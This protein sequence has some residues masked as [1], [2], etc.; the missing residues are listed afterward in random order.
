MN[1]MEL[2]Q[3]Y[4]LIVSLG[5]SCAPAINMRNYGLRKFSMPLDWMISFSLSDVNRL[6]LNKFEQFMILDN[7]HKL[8]ETHYFL[9]DGAPATPLAENS[10]LKSYFIRD[11]LYNII[12]AHDFPIVEGEHWSTSYPAFRAKIDSRI[13]RFWEALTNSRSILFIRWSASYEQVF[14]LEA[15]LSQQLKHRR[16]NILVLNP[17]HDL[18]SIRD[19]GWGFSNVCAMEVPYDMNDLTTWDTVLRGIGLE[20]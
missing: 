5:M 4:D 7:L 16:F 2:K 6:F 19:L 17:A 20:V 12:S 9:E 1:L 15:I 3:R 10:L 8:E 14:E 11:S 18:L 13:T